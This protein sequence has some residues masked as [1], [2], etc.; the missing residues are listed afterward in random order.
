MCFLVALTVYI[1]R[2]FEDFVLYACKPPLKGHS[3]HFLKHLRRSKGQYAYQ[4]KSQP[5]E[6]E[7]GK[8]L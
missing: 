5:I 3:L 7:G 4:Q 6:I 2:L 1:T 8:P